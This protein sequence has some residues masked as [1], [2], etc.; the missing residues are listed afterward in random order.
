MSETTAAYRLRLTD[1][2]LAR[3]ASG[4]A[5]TARAEQRPADPLLAQL[6]GPAARCKRKVMIWR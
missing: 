2:E 5:A 6:Y 3:I 4:G 1:D